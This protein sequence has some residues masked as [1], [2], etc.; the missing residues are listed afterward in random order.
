MVTKNTKV[1]KI[2]CLLIVALLFCHASVA[3]ANDKNNTTVKE[4]NKTKGKD[5]NVTKVDDMG[6]NSSRYN[7]NM[8]CQLGT[9][10][11]IFDDSS[12]KVYNQELTLKY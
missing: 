7:V 6:N 4:D 9:Q 2:F 10:F 3:N 8:S 1:N 12:C 5:D 11:K